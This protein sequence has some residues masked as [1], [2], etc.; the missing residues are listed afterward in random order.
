MKCVLA[1]TLVVLATTAAHAA[2]LPLRP[3]GYV[4]KG[5][6]CAAPPLA[7]MF[8]Y[9]GRE[10]TYPHASQCRFTV[11]SHR[12]HVY[13]LREVCSALGDGSS[14]AP[15]TT[16]S[17][18]EIASQTEILVSGAGHHGASHYRWC[19]PPTA[20][21]RSD[22]ETENDAAMARMMTGMAI[23]PSGSVDRD[24]A[25]MMIAHHQGAIDM[26]QAELRHGGNEQLR[27]I[28]QEIIVDQQQEIIAM[29]LAL[30][31]P[32]PASAPAPT[33]QQQS[34]PASGPQ[35]QSR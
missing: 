7:A 26:A 23:M 4:L 8:S 19:A 27:R 29:H 17:S 34:N 22:F 13:R 3:G 24:F 12:G 20:V 33:Q 21:G 16:V 11:L 2:S 6:P 31:D 30:G 5:Q 1:L 9:D 35:E 14:S 32:L 25:R 18:Y 10:F 15:A 28:A